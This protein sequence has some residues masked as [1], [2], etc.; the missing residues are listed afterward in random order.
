MSW[1]P[2][3]PEPRSALVAP[4]S[5]EPVPLEVLRTARDLIA[6]FRLPPRQFRRGTV[7][8]LAGY[9]RP[10]SDIVFVNPDI[11]DMQ[12]MGGHE[13]YYALLIH[14]LL[15]A[16]GHPSRL[17]RTSTGDFS[18][19]GDAR[20]EGTTYAAERIVLSEIGFPEEAVDWFAPD[21]PTLRY[22]NGTSRVLIVDWEAASEAAGWVL[23]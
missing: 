23:G 17:D 16:T 9:Y 7:N 10:S 12:G 20:E 19:L 13:G 18:T 4:G 5:P 3:L 15:H 6:N 11:A 14:E 1:R 22:E 21:G 8:G 2:F